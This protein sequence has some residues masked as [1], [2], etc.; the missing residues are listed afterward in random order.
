MIAAQ[1]WLVCDDCHET[2]DP[3]EKR[4][5]NSLRRILEAYGWSYVNAK[6]RCPTCTAKH[7]DYVASLGNRKQPKTGKESR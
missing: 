6:D 7:R 5:G 1:T 2:S 3:A 4:S